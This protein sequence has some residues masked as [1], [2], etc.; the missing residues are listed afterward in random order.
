MQTVKSSTKIYSVAVV[1][2]VYNSADTLSSLVAQISA[3][4][5]DLSFEILLVDDCSIDASWSVIQQLASE[6]PQVL[7]IRLAKKKLFQ[8]L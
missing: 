8:G 6:N 4:L 5:T 7:G 3:V 1:V 2:P